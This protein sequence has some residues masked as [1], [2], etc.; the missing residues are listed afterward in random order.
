MA[1]DVGVK[2]F[3]FNCEVTERE[4]TLKDRI[5]VILEHRKIP[6]HLAPMISSPPKPSDLNSHTHKGS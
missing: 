3:A 1:H 5:G 2:V 6:S 4:I